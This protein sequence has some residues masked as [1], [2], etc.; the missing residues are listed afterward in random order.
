MIGST[1][2]EIGSAASTAA[3][4][5]ARSNPVAAGFLLGAAG[6]GIFGYGA[7]RAMPLIGR[8]IER[9]TDATISALETRRSQ[10]GIAKVASA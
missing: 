10:R 4:M 2:T 7:Y 5:A 1:I 9:L 6:V 3:I 8:S